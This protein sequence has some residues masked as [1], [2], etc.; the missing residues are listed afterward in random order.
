[1]IRLF[2]CV[3][4]HLSNARNENIRINVRWIVK[5]TQKNEI[6]IFIFKNFGKKFSIWKKSRFLNKK[7]NLKIIFWIK[8][9]NVEGKI[10]KSWIDWGLFT[11]M[12]IRWNWTH[13]FR[14]ACSVMYCKTKHFAILYRLIFNHNG[15]YLSSSSNK[16]E[17]NFDH[18]YI[19]PSKIVLTRLISISTI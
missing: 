9:P 15:T 3:R 1:M 6:P 17:E 14:L 8:F 16:I 12:N 5:W 10:F 19:K 18:P 11:T 2:L 4:I 13:P 7:L